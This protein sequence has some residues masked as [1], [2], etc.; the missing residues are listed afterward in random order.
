MYSVMATS[1]AAAA[2]WACGASMR[3]R[4]R[5]AP[6]RSGFQR[7]VKVPSFAAVVWVIADQF[8]WRSSKRSMVTISPA[9]ALPVKVLRTPTR[10]P[11][12]VET[13]TPPC[14]ADA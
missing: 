13:E 4:T 7:A 2:V 5:A 11:V 14:A 10:P 3:A 12:R 6:A 9:R 1:G 8:F